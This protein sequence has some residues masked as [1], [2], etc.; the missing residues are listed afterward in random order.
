[1]PAELHANRMQWLIR[2]RYTLLC[3]CYVEGWCAPI[4][5]STSRNRQ[6]LFRPVMGLLLTFT[7]IS[8]SPED[9]QRKNLILHL[10]FYIKHGKVMTPVNACKV[11]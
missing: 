5:A 1:V 11:E 10:G 3:V 6:S 4:G 9:L 7:I 8:G 2:L